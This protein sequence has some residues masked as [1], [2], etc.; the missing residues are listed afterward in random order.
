MTL[1][2][3][4]TLLYTALL[5]FLLGLVAVAALVLMNRNLI[6]TLD[7]TLGDEY[8]AVEKL[9]GQLA[10]TS[11]KTGAERDAEG[12]IPRARYLFPNDAIQIENLGVY[13]RQTLIDGL[14]ANQPGA[15]RAALIQGVRTIQK[16]SRTTVTGISD[17]HP[18]ILTDDELV[19]LVQS[20]GGRII[21]N[22]TVKPPYSKAG[23][24]VP[25]RVLVTIGEMQLEPVSAAP[26][27]LNPPSSYVISYVGRSLQ[28]IQ[29]TMTSL[30]RVFLLLFLS[31]LLLSGVGAYFLAGQALRPLRQVR[32]AAEGISGQNLGERVPEPQTGDEVQALA[33][34]LNAMLGRL[35]ASFE[36]QRRFTSDAS[37]ELRTPVTAI[38]GH[39]SYLLRRTN[40][41]GQQAESLRIIQ[42]E[43]ERLTNLIA[44]LL[45]LARSDS[46]AL[47]MT[48]QPIF[49]L[50]FLTDVARE[51]EPLATAQDSTLTTSGQDVPFEGDP[52]RLRQVI[53]NLVGNALK[54]GAKTVT[55]AST[56]QE[57]G[58]EVRLSVC[59]DGPG[60]PPE[61]LER[62]FD[63]FYRV[64]DS[65]SRDQG[66]AGLGLSIAKGIVD[67]HHGRIWLESEPGT[68][69]TVHVQLPIGNIPEFDDEDVP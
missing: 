67:A 57:G 66:G 58:Q 43:S 29:Q 61:H 56:P 47:Q 50:M 39:A 10:L 15:R 4:L 35:E 1:R 23:T 27:D 68:G 18:F 44:S 11:M 62:L 55:L 53:I 49:S 12:V 34:S 54:A 25:Y 16:Y 42:S 30:Q 65:R 45:Q 6:G 13:D 21:V 32:Q 14:A 26:I 40:P 19:N 69:T 9:I 7:A 22:R 63:R 20:P 28:P 36:A 60:I 24:L 8:R 2:W 37:H 48:L 59:D 41:S 46:G 64:E 52:D 5:A 38:Q 3:R 51:L 33:A 17:Q 31:G